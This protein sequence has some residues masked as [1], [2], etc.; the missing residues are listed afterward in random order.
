[1]YMQR[2]VCGLSAKRA[3]TRQNNLYILK[4][5]KTNIINYN[6]LYFFGREKT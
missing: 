3:N 5:E 1:M 6:V 4:K 2:G